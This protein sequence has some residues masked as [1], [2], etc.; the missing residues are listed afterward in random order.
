ME[1]ENLKSCPA[2]RE[3]YAPKLKKI[4]D[5]CLNHLDFV[6]CLIMPN[7]KSVGAHCFRNLKSLRRLD[8]PRLKTAGY[9]FLHSTSALERFYAPNLKNRL[10]FLRYHKNYRLIL[11]NMDEPNTSRNKEKVPF[12][13]AL[14]Y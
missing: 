2:I 10:N 12:F 4:G 11:R 3:V 8:V 7:L 6:T 14:I 5:S 1:D 9:R 13:R